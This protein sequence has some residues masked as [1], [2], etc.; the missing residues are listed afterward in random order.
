MSI[1][2]KAARVGGDQR[3]MM[4]FVLPWLDFGGGP[5]EEIFIR[6]GVGERVFFERLHS[7]ASDNSFTGPEN[8]RLKVLDVC[9]RRG[10]V[11]GSDHRE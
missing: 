11:V 3:H 6:F 8:I 2:T 5:S 10:A 9:R 4:D 1:G 7:F